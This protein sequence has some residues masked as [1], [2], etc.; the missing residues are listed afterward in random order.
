MSIIIYLKFNKDVDKN[1]SLCWEA[2][3]KGLI[4]NLNRL[5][6]AN[7]I[8]LLCLFLFLNNRVTYLIILN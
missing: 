4:F 3:F 2:E 5:T 6:I 7:Y 1:G 8:L